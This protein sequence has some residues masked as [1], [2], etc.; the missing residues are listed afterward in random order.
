MTLD[1]PPG[2][3]QAEAV[4]YNERV[5]RRDGVERVDEDGTV[6]LTEECRAAVAGFAPD[7]ALPLAVADLAARL[8]R[9]L[10]P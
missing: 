10:A 1:L 2:L 5:G 3:D 9:V 6:H 4:A 7:L 8:D